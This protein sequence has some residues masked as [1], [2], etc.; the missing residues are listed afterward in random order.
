MKHHNH[1]PLITRSDVIAVVRKRDGRNR[2]LKER[3]SKENQK[4]R[5]EKKNKKEK[6]KQNT[7]L[8][9]AY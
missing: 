2:L 8:V 3:T 4:K 6:G 9:A 5:E 1:S 7:T